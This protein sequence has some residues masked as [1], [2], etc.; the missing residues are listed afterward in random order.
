MESA[1]FTNAKGQS[2]TIGPKPFKL[3]KIDGLGGIETDIQTEK[4]PFQDGETH[5][6]TLLEPRSIPIETGIFAASKEILWQRRR[7]LV[8]LFNPKLGPGTLHYKNDLGAWEI[9][10]ISD[11]A[12][13]F[14]SGP[15][16]QANKFQRALIQLYCPS[17]FLLDVVETGEEIV[18]W[19]GGISFPLKLPSA[20]SMAGDKIKNIINV[21]DVA[22]P[23]K[24]EIFG[25]AT[26]PKVKNKSTGEYIKV[27][28][29]LLADDALIITTEFGNKR[30]ELNG[31]NVFNYIDSSSKF[32][33][34]QVGDNVIELTTEDVTDDVKVKI[35]Y[36]N[37]FVGV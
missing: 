21:G 6:D 36:R 34:L 32:F 3:F 13:V 23:I 15:E 33:N 1:T 22:T 37:R 18:T 28:R 19:I 2:I 20:F 8:Q 17:P 4:A 7:Q 12:P 35:S 10:A 25:T 27:N 24:I 9:K 30:V 5:I 14:P 29:T 31:Q 11:L 16:N 26:N